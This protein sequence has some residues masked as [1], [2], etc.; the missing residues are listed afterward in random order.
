MECPA[1]C[2]TQGAS[3]TSHLQP[4]TSRQG[5]PPGRHGPPP[6]KALSRGTL[7]PVDTLP[8]SLELATDGQEKVNG[9]KSDWGKEP[10]RGSPGAGSGEGSQDPP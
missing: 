2:S 5:P 4:H 7:T 1:R 10:K 3:H 9:A 6:G 8:S